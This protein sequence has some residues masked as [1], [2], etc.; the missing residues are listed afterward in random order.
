MEPIGFQG[1]T[2]GV[3]KGLPRRRTDP[4]AAETRIDQECLVRRADPHGTDATPWLAR[5]RREFPRWGFIHDPFARVWIAVRGRDRTEVAA[6]A[7]E[8]RER[9]TAASQDRWRR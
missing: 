7:F 8:L 9:L 4:P 6:T 1:P 3:R 2:G 5:L